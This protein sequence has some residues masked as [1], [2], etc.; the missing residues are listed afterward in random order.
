MR[1]HPA[2]GVVAEYVL[3]DRKDLDP[4]SIED[5]DAQLG[6]RQ[7]PSQQ[8]KVDAASRRLDASHLRLVEAKRD[9]EIPLAQIAHPPHAHH[10]SSHIDLSGIDAIEPAAVYLVP[11]HFGPSTAGACHLPPT[12][13]RHCTEMAPGDLGS[14]PTP[15]LMPKTHQRRSAAQDSVDLT[16][17]TAGAIRAQRIARHSSARIPYV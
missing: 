15:P 2:I 13:H 8:P 12:L 5:C 14:P 11:T 6:E 1:R 10:D 4:V 3:R 7:D 9:P 16:V 17:M